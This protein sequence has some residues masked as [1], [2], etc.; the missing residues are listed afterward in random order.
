MEEQKPQGEVAGPTP[1]DQSK[2]MAALAYIGPLVI[3]SYLVAKDN[4]FVKFH[5]KQALL[6]L[7]LWVAVWIVSTTFWWFG[8][9]VVWNIV[10]FIFFVLM[11]I[12]LVN[13]FQG[14]EKELPFIGHFANSFKI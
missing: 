4:P 8:L 11:V 1:V 7:V 3:V 6:L 13:V 5:I 2:L 10:K 12:G 14:K 9:W